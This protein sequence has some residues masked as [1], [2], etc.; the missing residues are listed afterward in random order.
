M[1]AKRTQVDV[2]VGPIENVQV[3]ALKGVEFSSEVDHNGKNVL[4][5][6]LPAVQLDRE[7]LEELQARTGLLDSQLE[8]LALTIRRYSIMNYLLPRMN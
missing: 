4:L 5:L 3:V 8:E 1:S 7:L 2:N 6:R